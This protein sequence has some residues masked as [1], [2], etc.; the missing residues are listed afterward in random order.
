M[1]RENVSN[2]VRGLFKKEK[3]LVI[4]LIALLSLGALGAMASITDKNGEN[5]FSKL[6]VTVGL[7]TNSATPLVPP[8]GTLQISKEYIYAGGRMLAT[9]D[10]G[11]AQVNPTPTPIPPPEGSTPTPTPTPTQTPTP[12]PTPTPTQTPT[13]TPTPV[14]CYSIKIKEQN[15]LN[16]GGVFNVATC[17]C[18]Y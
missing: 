12:T 1:N 13:P 11:V 9:E 2:K 15:C 7:K 10:Y 4:G 3:L 17:Q 18:E 16:Q 6:A 5:L 14:A 8:T